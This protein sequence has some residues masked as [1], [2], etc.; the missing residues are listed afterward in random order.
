MDF[1]DQSK[2]RRPPHQD[3]LAIVPPKKGLN[4]TQSSRKRVSQACHQCRARKDKCDGQRP[5]CSACTS[6]G[7]SCS[8]DP[9]MRKRGLPEGYVR[10]LESH[11]Q[12][13]E[14]YTRDLEIA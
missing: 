1:A 11:T 13:L 10:D 5:S 8:Y 6:R 3:P 4:L 14:A 9:G 12:I 2:G 7:K